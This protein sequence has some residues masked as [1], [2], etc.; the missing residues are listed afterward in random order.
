MFI[1]NSRYRIVSALVPGI[2]PANPFK[3]QPATFNYAMF[4]DGFYA[5]LRAG[6]LKDTGM[7]SDFGKGYLIQTYHTRKQPLHGSSSFKLIA[8]S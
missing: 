3:G 5:I 4:L 2:T 6:R 1:Q 7:R 8:L